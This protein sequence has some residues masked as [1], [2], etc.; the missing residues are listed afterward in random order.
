MKD[1]IRE[2]LPEIEWIQNKDLQE[3]VVVTFEDALKMGGWEPEDMAK[4]PFTLLIKD[5]PAS[6]LT[7]TRGVTRICKVSMDEYN[8]LYK[9]EGGFQLDND[10]LI[11][12]ALLHDVGKLVEYER[13]TEGKVV[14]SKLGKDLRHPFSGTAL[15]MKN[16]VSSEICHC[17]AVHAGEGDGRHRSPEGVMVNKA[18]FMNFETIKSFMGL[19]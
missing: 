5:C 11:A 18:D 2:C 13:N 6:F 4:I 16:G 9:N 14:K 1:R 10:I 3:K 7:H 8:A 15:A 19:L 17:I 12:A